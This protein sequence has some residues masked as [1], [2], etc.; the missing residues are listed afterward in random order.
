ME[1]PTYRPLKKTLIAVSLVIALAGA[2]VAGAG[3]LAGGAENLYLPDFLH[4][5]LSDG[6]PDDAQ[7]S[8]AREPAL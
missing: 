3:V 6:D 1:R 4:A 7:P 8:T 5:A 2:A